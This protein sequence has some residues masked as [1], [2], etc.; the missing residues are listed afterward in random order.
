MCGVGC[1][2]PS[3]EIFTSPDRRETNGRMRF[4][5]PVFRYGQM[6]KGI[7]LK[8]KN[9]VIVDYDATENKAL[10]KEII[11]IPN[12]NK[13]GEFSL[14]DSR[15]SHITKLMGETLFDENMG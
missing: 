6:I 3:F 10:L 14:T 1:N 11:S 13:L 15:F 8:F 2:I 7:F 9:G 5:Q 4:N 12:A